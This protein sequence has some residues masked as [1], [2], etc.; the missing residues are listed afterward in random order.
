MVIKI[1]GFFV[2]TINILLFVIY[3]STIFLKK[4]YNY[5]MIIIFNILILNN[6]SLFIFYIKKTINKLKHIKNS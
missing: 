6:I 3:L 1:F 4:T 5:N 2:L